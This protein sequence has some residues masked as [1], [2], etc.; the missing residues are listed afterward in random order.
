MIGRPGGTPER[1]ALFF[2]DAAEFRAWLEANHATAFELWMGLAKKHVTP[3]G[4]TWADAVPQALCFGWIDSVAQRIDDDVTRQRWT[5]RKKGSNWSNINV[6][7]VE[8]LT[9]EGLM[10]PAG[11]AAFEARTTGRTGIYTYEVDE[12]HFT[13]EHAGLLAANPAASAW[14]DAAPAT[15]RRIALHWV[16]SAKQQATR[17]RRIA[18]LVDD[19]AA[20]RLIS[21]QRYGDEPS[22]V[23]RNRAALGLGEGG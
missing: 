23:A 14:W 5:P 4:L 10:T 19:S 21:T 12:E 8:R 13:P 6:A 11:I 16:N 20:G 22:W 3:R 2:A 15:Y 18:Q 1:P 17:D 7:H 9:A